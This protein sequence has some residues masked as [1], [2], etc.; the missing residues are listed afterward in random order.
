M[1]RV[2]GEPRVARGGLDRALAQPSRLVGPSRR[3]ADAAHRLVGPAA[4]ADDAA[5]REPLAELLAFLH[6][7]QRLARLTE[8]RE[9]PRRRGDGGAQKHQ[10]V[11]GPE[12]LD[13]V[14][15]P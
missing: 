14:L 4:M 2:G 8:L 7:A 12:D 15:D 6:A 5:R 10:D 9:H 1:E 3:E 13:P 11:P